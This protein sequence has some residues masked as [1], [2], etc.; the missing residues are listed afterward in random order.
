[1]AV[2]DLLANIGTALDLVERFI[3]GDTSINP[4]N[5]LNGIRITLTNVRGHMCR[6]AEEAVNMQNLHHTANT[7]INDL[8]TELANLRTDSL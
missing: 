3:G 5:T 6:T 8:R 1:M 7:R 2:P 4:T